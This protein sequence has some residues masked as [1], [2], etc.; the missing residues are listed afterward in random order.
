MWRASSSHTVFIN[1]PKTVFSC[2]WIS[3]LKWSV[4]QSHFYEMWQYKRH[5]KYIMISQCM[6]IKSHTLVG[7]WFK[8]FSEHTDRKFTSSVKSQNKR[9]RTS[10]RMYM[11]KGC[12]FLIRKSHNKKKLRLDYSLKWLGR[13]DSYNSAPDKGTLNCNHSKK[14]RTSSVNE[15]SINGGE[16]NVAKQKDAQLTSSQPLIKSSGT[17]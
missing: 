4:Y 2:G 8:L 1:K 3:L 10:A 17:R 14:P 11:G 16:Y 9:A 12:Y 13:L 6:T 5:Q 15:T 7:V